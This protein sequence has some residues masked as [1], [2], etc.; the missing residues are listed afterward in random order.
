[1][2]LS[3]DHW[4][5]LEQLSQGPVPVIPLPALEG[6]WEGLSSEAAS[7]AYLEANSAARYLIDRYGMH[8]I[9]QLLARLKQKQTLP[10]A[11]QTQLSLSYDQFQSRWLEQLHEERKKG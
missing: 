8:E 3:N 5:N 11:M 9:R 4:T 7:A 2:Q 1:M 6:S 10:A